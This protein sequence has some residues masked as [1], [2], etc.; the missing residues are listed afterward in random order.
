MDSL[1]RLEL[2][3]QFC[4]DVVLAQGCFKPNAPGRWELSSLRALS[5][6]QLLKSQASYFAERIL[7][8]VTP[9]QVVAIA[10]DAL[11]LLCRRCLVWSRE[12]LRVQQMP[13]RAEQRS[14]TDHALLLSNCGWSPRLEIAPMFDDERCSTVVELLMRST[15]PRRHR[16]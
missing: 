3:Q 9:V 5:E 2:A 12:E 11:S 16:V 8:A 4:D 1:P 15:A 14:P 7:V 13:S 6:R 10:T